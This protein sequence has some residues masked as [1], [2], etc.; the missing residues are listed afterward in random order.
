MMSK[1]V[2]Q[3]GKGNINQA[4]KEEEVDVTMSGNEEIVVVIGKETK[5]I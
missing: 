2:H 1:C 3:R 5:T 4:E